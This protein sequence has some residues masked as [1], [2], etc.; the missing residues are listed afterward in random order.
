[1]NTLSLKVLCL[2]SAGCSLLSC[3]PIHS[4]V[5]IVNAHAL[6]QAARVAGAG[7]SARYELALAHEYIHKAREEYGYSDFSAAE[8]Y[9]EKAMKFA[10]TAKDKALTPKPQINDVVTKSK[11]QN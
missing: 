4:G 7:Q 10:Q 11:T 1:M 5:Q 2:I 3:A 8:L 6:V 9:A